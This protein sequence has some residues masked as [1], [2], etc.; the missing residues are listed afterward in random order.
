MQKSRLSRLLP[1]FAM[2]TGIAL[3]GVTSAFKEAPISHAGSYFYEFVGDQ[4]VQSEVQDRTQYQRVD[5][6]CA[7]TDGDLCGIYLPNDASSNA[8]PSATDFSPHETDLW[9]SAQAETSQD[10]NVI[11]MK[12]D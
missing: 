3:V 9:N 10:Q 4:T 7:K 8:N 12:A 11:E 6:G 2:A 5:A 1:L